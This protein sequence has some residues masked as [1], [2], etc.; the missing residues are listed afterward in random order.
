MAQAEKAS[1]RFSWRE[2]L[3]MN[4][5]DIV[6]A[7]LLG[8]IEAVIEIVGA[9]G[10]LERTVWA[11]GPV[12]FVIY[13]IYNGTT[14]ILFFAGAYLRKRASVLLL[15]IA[16][17][18]IVRWFMGDPDGPLLLWYALFPG[19]LT[20]IAFYAM[21][22]RGGN[23]LFAVTGAVA[24]GTNQI[25]LFVVVGF[26]LAGGASWGILSIIVGAIGGLLWGVV[27]RYLGVG[28]GRAGVPS[29]S[30]PPS[31]TGEAKYA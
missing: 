29:V 27:G 20:V 26:G 9:L 13:A 23:F 21:R 24:A 2:D 18:H 22:W 6:V 4:T 16:V 19:I 5:M 1:P 8:I 3:R 14:W 28:L 12:G 17:T 10:F 31:R 25:A 7:V 15:A 30:N 11:T